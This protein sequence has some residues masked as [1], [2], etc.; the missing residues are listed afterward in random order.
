MRMMAAD[1]ALAEAGISD[2]PEERREEW[3]SM[4]LARWGYFHHPAHVAAA[5]VDPEFVGRDWT[6]EQ[7]PNSDEPPE[8]AQFESTIDQLAQTPGAEEDGHTAAAIMVEYRQWVNAFKLSG[9]ASKDALSKDRVEQARKLPAWQWW[10]TFGKRWPHLRWFAMRLTAQ[11]CS[12][13]ACERNWSLYEW[14]HNNRR[15]QLSVA[16]AEKLVRSHSN[17]N[18]INKHHS[19]ASSCVPWMEE[20]VIDEPEEVVDV[21]DPEDDAPTALTAGVPA[22][23]L[24]QSPRLAEARQPSSRGSGRGRGRGDAVRAHANLFGLH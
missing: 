15:N 20:M 24:R 22:S 23:S 16:R 8:C 13:C 3:H 7:D 19:V 17:I 2:F 11:V 5:F 18:L 14:I 9:T 21:S 6:D 10:Q 1:I 12:A 4:L